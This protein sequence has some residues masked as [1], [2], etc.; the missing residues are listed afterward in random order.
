MVYKSG[1]VYCVAG[2]FLPIQNNLETKLD[3]V[4][5]FEKQND[6]LKKRLAKNNEAKMVI[7]NALPRKEYERIFM[8]NTAKE[9]WKNLVDHPSSDEEGSTSESEDE[10]YAMAVRD[11]KRIGRFVGQPQN[12]KKTFQRSRD[13]KNDKSDRKCFRC[14]DLNHLIRECPKTPRDKNQRAFVGGSWSDSGEEDDEKA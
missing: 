3:K 4:V 2:V 7:Y 1:S 9:I 14:G 13:D 5:P 11:F 12:D 6:D 8:C 10:E